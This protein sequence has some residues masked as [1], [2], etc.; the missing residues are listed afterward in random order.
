LLENPDCHAVLSRYAAGFLL[1]PDMS[2]AMEI[3]LEQIAANHPTHISKELLA[4]IDTDL[5]KIK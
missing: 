4:K 1:M 3:T 5:A 2:G